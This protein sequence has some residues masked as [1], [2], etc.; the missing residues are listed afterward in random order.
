MLVLL[1]VY[2]DDNLIVANDKAALK[3]FE[4]PF[5]KQS[6]DSLMDLQADV[7]SDFV[8]VKYEETAAGTIELSCQRLLS[9]LRR[10]L[11]ALPEDWRLEAGEESDTPMAEGALEKLRESQPGGKE[12]EALLCGKRV[13]RL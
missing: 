8:G 2:V 10:K 7:S 11:E 1:C 5:N 6:P 3:E 4:A 9:D 13:K 12:A